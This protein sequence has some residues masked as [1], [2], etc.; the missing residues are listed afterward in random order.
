MF[1][2]EVILLLLMVINELNFLRQIL[3]QVLLEAEV[4]AEAKVQLDTEVNHLALLDI[5]AHHLAQLEGVGAV[6]EAYHLAQLE[7]E[8]AEA[9]IV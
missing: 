3:V 4:E 7:E 9:V 6:D 5:G 8:G 2:L 1:P